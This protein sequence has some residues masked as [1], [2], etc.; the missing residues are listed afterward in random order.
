MSGSGGTGQLIRTVLVLG[1]AGFVVVQ[2]ADFLASRGSDHREAVAAVTS[3]PTT[4]RQRSTQQGN[5]GVAGYELVV[6]AGSGGHY[7]VNARVDGVQI[8]FMVDTGASTVLLTVADAQRLGLHQATLD[9]SEVYQTANGIIRGAPV[10]IG[11]LKI[12]RESIYNVKATVTDTPGGISLL[13]MTFLHR[14]A[15]YQVQSGRLVLRW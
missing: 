9:F 2:T 10:E 8:R 14:L 5:V 12:G 6:R 3:Q 7:L 11:E 4:T 1:F 15:S 13:G